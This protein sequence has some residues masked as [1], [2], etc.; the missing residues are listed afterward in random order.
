MHVILSKDFDF[1]AAQALPSFPE[2]HKC[3]RTHGHSF[4]LTVSVRGEVDPQKGVLYD[5]GKISEAV[6]PLIEQL[7]HYYLN[8]IEGLS[9]PT[10]ENMAGWFWNKLKDKLPGLYEITIQETARTRCIYRGD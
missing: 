6:C 8:D 4:K 1:E 2:G 10:I 3:R 5:H 9:N 7:D